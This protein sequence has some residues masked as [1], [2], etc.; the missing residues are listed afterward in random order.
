M[1]PSSSELLNETGQFYN[2]P[3]NLR[4]WWLY[5]ML[6]GG[7][8][9]REKLALF[10]HNHFATSY[11]KVRSTKLM[12][13]QNVTIRKHALGKFRPFLLDMSKDTA[14]LIWLDSNQNVK[15]APNEN[16]AR[17][18]MELFSLGVGNYTEKD[19][20]EAARA[21]TGWHHDAEQVT[22]REQPTAARRRMRRR[23]SARPASG[24]ATDIIRIC[25]DQPA[26]A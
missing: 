15:G 11:A 19:V 5:A 24:P 8:P 12:Y 4:V 1:R 20:Q 7:H 13:E 6:E 25:C 2:E 16:Y 3:G 26:C 23:S 22:V 9:L 18:V 14:M 10:W 21:F 17:E